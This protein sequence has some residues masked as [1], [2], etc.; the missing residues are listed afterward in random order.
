MDGP[1]PRSESELSFPGNQPSLAAPLRL[2]HR[3]SRRAVVPASPLTIISLTEARSMIVMGRFRHHARKASS[4][5]SSSAGRSPLSTRRRG[6]L[7][8]GTPDPTSHVLVPRAETHGRS[9][10]SVRGSPQRLPRHPWSSF[11][12]ETTSDSH[13]LSAAVRRSIPPR[14]RCSPV[15]SRARGSTTRGT[16]PRLTLQA[17]CDAS[18]SVSPR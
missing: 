12:A 18:S 15:P 7:L 14:E 16:T 1:S 10:C 2:A 11:V 5:D 17:A 13:E 8:M 9:T 4:S 6:R 3:A